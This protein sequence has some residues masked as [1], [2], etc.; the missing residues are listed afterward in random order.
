MWSVVI[1]VKGTSNSKSRFGPTDNRELAIAMALDTVTAALSAA[2]VDEVIVVT[3]LAEPVAHL[4]SNLG[5][6]LVIDPGEGLGAAIETG[7]AFAGAASG[8]SGAVTG[9]ARTTSAGRDPVRAR[10][11]GSD[12]VLARN[13]AVLLGDLPA[14][15][16]MELGAALK[17]AA[18]YPR[19]IVADSDGTGTTLATATAGHRHTL[20]FGPR[21]RAAHLAAG[22]VELTGEWPGLARDVDLPDHLAGVEHAL[23]EHT[24]AVLRAW[25]NL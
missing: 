7:L 24:A 22:Y 8:P 19:A 20:S 15:R 23:G 6:I 9:S 21:S 17:A 3:A 13:R 10:S 11:T 2:D 18:R 25:G 5:A 16:P 14:L 4:F 12:P 1:P